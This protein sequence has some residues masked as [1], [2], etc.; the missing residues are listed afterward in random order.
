MIAF[1]MKSF[2]TEH[3]RNARIIPAGIEHPLP[4]VRLGMGSPNGRRG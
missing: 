3:V 2:N 1:F 4:T